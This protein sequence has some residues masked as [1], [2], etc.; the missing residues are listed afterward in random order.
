MTK[1]IFFNLPGLITG[2][3]KSHE[4]ALSKITQK[5]FNFFKR[6]SF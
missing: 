2:S 3:Q 1:K 4:A 6:M 5:L